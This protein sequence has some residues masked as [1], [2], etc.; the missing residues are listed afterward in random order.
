MDGK[1]RQTTDQKNQGSGIEGYIQN[2]EQNESTI[3]QR[4]KSINDQ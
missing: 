3:W 1:R 2:E 4:M